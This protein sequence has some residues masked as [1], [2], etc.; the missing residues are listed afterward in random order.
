MDLFAS[1][2]SKDHGSSSMEFVSKKQHDELLQELRVKEDKF[3]QKLQSK[4]RES[5]PAP[6]QVSSLLKVRVC[7]GNTN[8]ILSIWSPSEEIVDALKEGAC[9][10]LC[11]VI[12]SGKRYIQYKFSCK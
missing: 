3:K 5:L 6:R 4:L 1:Q 10:S 7:D 12:A 9:V 2:F 11:N 8:A